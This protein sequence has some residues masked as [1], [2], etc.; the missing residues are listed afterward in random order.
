ML[1]QAEHMTLPT[2]NYYTQRILLFVVYSVY[3]DRNYI[4][5]AN[6]LM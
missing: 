2:T 4:R 1:M 3:T 6:Q 5:L